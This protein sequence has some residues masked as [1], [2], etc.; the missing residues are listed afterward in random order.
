M[1]AIR[2]Q[3]LSVC[4]YAGFKPANSLPTELE[5]Q[6]RPAIEIAK[7][8][9]AIKAIVLW[10]MVPPE[11]LPDEEILDFAER[12]QLE[13]YIAEDE[14][15]ILESPRNDEEARNLIGWKFENAWPLAWYFGYKEPDFTGEMMTGVQMQEI[16]ND[17]ACPLDENIE[18]WIKKRDVISEEKLRKK[19]D[20]FYCI[21]NAVR[22]AQ[23]GRKTV[24]ENFDPIA[25]GGVIHERG[26]ALTWM[27]SNGVS[28]NDMDLST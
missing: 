2:L 16:L 11:N 23:M 24:P 12:N 17:H 5:T 14:K 22:S 1:T 13:D 20:L 28:W 10:I 18:D 9:H 26:H 6:I 3:N 27:L 19:E 25:N 8:L 15:L 4:L 7:R 21:H